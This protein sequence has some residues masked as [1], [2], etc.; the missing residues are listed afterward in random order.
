MLMM[1][2][3][4]LEEGISYLAY[5]P[6]EMSFDITVSLNNHI[7]LMQNFYL[8][9]GQRLTK[10]Q[11]SDIKDIC[12][13]VLNLSISKGTTSRMLTARAI[14]LKLV[15]DILQGNEYNYY[16]ILNYAKDKAYFYKYDS[17]LL[18]YLLEQV[19]PYLPVQYCKE[20]FFML[21]Y[22]MKTGE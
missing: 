7:I 14:N 17:C 4:A 18:L 11:V 21:L 20:T 10:I 8:V 3:H 6:Q 19:R 12:T 9:H 15:C 1:V 22:F 16:Q 13:A 2:Y 5:Y